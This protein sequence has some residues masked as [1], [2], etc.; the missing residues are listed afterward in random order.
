MKT[1]FS[2]KYLIGII[3]ALKFKQ[4]SCLIAWKSIC[5]CV[6]ERWKR[7]FA[8]LIHSYYYYMLC[9]LRILD[10]RKRKYPKKWTNKEMNKGKNEMPHDLN[11]FG[12]SSSCTGHQSLLKSLQCN[13]WIPV[14][15]IIISSLSCL[16]HNNSLK[17]PLHRNEKNEL[18]REILI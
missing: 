7:T 14:T 1:K 9:I 15:R 2:I 3:I 12:S 17:F 5:E 11:F 10:S 4:R 6:Y 18:K 8:S 13:S 16:A